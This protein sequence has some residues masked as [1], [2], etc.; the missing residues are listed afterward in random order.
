MDKKSLIKQHE[1]EIE[2]I[3][4]LLSQKSA[5]DFENEKAAADWYQRLCT[6]RHIRQSKLDALK[7]EVEAERL[8]SS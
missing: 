2:R 1:D 4:T 5:R 3:N 6:E 8:L 7:K